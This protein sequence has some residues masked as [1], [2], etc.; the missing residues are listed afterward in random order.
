[1]V[2]SHEENSEN[3]QTS[4]PSAIFCPKVFEESV[5]VGRH[6]YQELL[7]VGFPW[8]VPSSGR[9]AL[10]IGREVALLPRLCCA[11]SLI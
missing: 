6:W 5:Q 4:N 2:E 11:G 3:G 9:C 1:M 8:E 7:S 10:R